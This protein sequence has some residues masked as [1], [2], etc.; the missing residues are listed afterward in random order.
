MS[1]PAAVDAVAS[2]AD[3]TPGFAVIQGAQVAAALE[4]RPR[5]GTTRGVRPLAVLTAVLMPLGPAAVAVIRLLCPRTRPPP[6][7][8]PAP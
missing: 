6:W 2:P 1:S 3:A 5:T 7:P 4:G 8:S